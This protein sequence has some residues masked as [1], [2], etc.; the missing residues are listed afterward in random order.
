MG[1]VKVNSNM[2][3][4]IENLYAIGEVSRTGL[5]GQTGWL[6]IRFWSV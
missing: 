3:T 5:M 4:T 6:Q 1:G 2:E